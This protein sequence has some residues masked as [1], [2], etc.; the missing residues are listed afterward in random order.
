M[1]KTKTVIDTSEL[2]CSKK[3]KTSKGEGLIESLKITELG[4]VMLRVYYPEEKC[5]INYT[6]S[7]I[8]KLLE[9][10]DIELVSK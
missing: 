6:V 9:G 1:Q 7:N 5:F 8:I 10:S 2:M 4:F 3:V